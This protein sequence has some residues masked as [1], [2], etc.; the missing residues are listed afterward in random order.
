MPSEVHQIFLGRDRQLADF[1]RFLGA[2]LSTTTPVPRP[3]IVLL[4]GQGGIGKTSLLSAFR[5][6]LGPAGPFRPALLE[7]DWHEEQEKA[8]HRFPS[9]ADQVSAQAVF[10]V[11]DNQATVLP[12]WVKARKVYK[13]AQERI[14]KAKKRAEKE[15]AGLRDVRATSS[16][17]TDV[18]AKTAGEA[19]SVSGV[20][21]AKP[22]VEW[23]VKLG[24]TVAPEWA[25]SLHAKLSPIDI[26]L[27]E[28]F[29]QHLAR[30]LGESL[31]DL[32]ELTSNR[33]LVVM[34]DTY[35]IVDERDP[36]FREVL[37]AAGP[38]VA[39]VIAGRNNLY[40]SR[41]NLKGRFDG[42]LVGRG[43][44]WDVLEIDVKALAREEIRKFFLQ[45]APDRQPLSDDELERVHLATGAIPL[46]ISLAAE[47]WQQG[48][49][50]E[51]I[52]TEESVPKERIVEE[53]VGRYEQHCVGQDL[54]R[55]ALAAIAMAGGDAE[56]LYALLLQEPE[57]GNEER[58]LRDL[59]ALVRDRYSSVLK[60][61]GGA[62]SLHDEP[63]RFYLERMRGRRHEA[64]VRT[65]N[66]RA[67]AYFSARLRELWDYY[68]SLEDLCD[69][70]D[71]VRES[72]RLTNHLFW[73][74]EIEAWPWLTAR[75]VE[76]IGYS[77]VLRKG[78]LD[79][80]KSWR[81]ELK[82]IGQKRLKILLA[83]EVSP[84]LAEPLQA[85]RRL[86]EEDERRG[87]LD[88][89]RLGP[90]R[91]AAERRAIRLGSAAA[92][93]LQANQIDEAFGFLKQAEP[94]VPLGGELARRLAD[95]GIRLGYEFFERVGRKG[96]RTAVEACQLAVRLDPSNPLVH[97]EL[98]SSYFWLK[99][100]EKA[101]EHHRKAI[102]LNPQD[103][104]AWCALGSDY[105]LRKDYE[106]AIEHHRKA[107]ELNP[108]DGAA[109]CELGNDYIWLKDYDKGIEHHRKA[110]EL[111]PQN[112][113][114]L[115]ALGADFIL[116][117]RYE[118]AP[119]PLERS[120]AIAPDDVS[121]WA[122]LGYLSML[123]G[124]VQTAISRFEKVRALDPQLGWP[125]RLWACLLYR[126]GEWPLAFEKARE[127]SV[128]ESKRAPLTSL[129][130]ERL[131]GGTVDLDRADIPERVV[132]ERD[133]SV[134]AQW[135][136]LQGKKT[137]ALARLGQAIQKTPDEA[138]FARF[139][140][141]FHDL[142][143]DSRFIAMTRDVPGA[144]WTDFSPA[145][146]VQET[147]VG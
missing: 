64:W 27:I 139:L 48:G 20:P 19:A 131:V 7:I 141:A 8:P 93:L 46:A 2:F 77:S 72:V 62:P 15:Y 102:E 138:A 140:P 58:V 56:L 145:G 126:L 75:F 114:A 129:A 135:L 144:T 109:W 147:P 52:V 53:M 120:N 59:I 3:Q 61:T 113:D 80:A 12:A 112:E 99:D 43:H 45:A 123:V 127:A 49:T 107:I 33:R 86:F 65:L 47:I 105:S 60:D 89:T 97:R 81:A 10:N 133:Q 106:K 146:T 57:I 136:A 119:Q 88:E 85:R 38:R 55:I 51:E 124:D 54:H 110:I 29:E 83:A 30:G 32:A 66:E 101:I 115:W 1:D 125:V 21:L 137:E 31:A 14:G 42:Y 25:A 28:G 108:Q 16:A 92:A 95:L 63:A 76:G 50:V 9:V 104:T 128:L 5:Q 35:E 4:W 26:E 71:Y 82:A 23:L 111:N 22:L 118:D 116:L 41:T 11:I 40:D 13:E 74:N 91:F 44:D 18:V 69:N 36:L 143:S 70:D 142:R 24:L 121:T 96:D 117:G 68:G 122:W 103:G 6:R 90:D 73:L 78:L 34:F 134:E 98:G 37:R 130:L 79:V 94:A 84:W 100:Y 17:A 132:W 39:W 87:W 67:I